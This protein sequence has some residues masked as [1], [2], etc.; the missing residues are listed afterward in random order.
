MLEYFE[1][2]GFK[3]FSWKLVWDFSA[4]RDY[5][6]N[7]DCLSS[8]RLGKVLVCGKNSVGKTN[9]GLALF[10][11]TTH[12]IGGLESEFYNYYLSAVPECEEAAFRYC[13]CFGEDRVTYS[14]RKN[15]LRG[16]TYERLELN[17]QQVLEWQL[18][19]QITLGYPLNTVHG[20]SSVKNLRVASWTT[21]L[22]LNTAL[23]ED[24]PLKQ[25]LQFVRNMLWFH[26]SDKDLHIGYSSQTAD[27]YN[28]ATDSGVLEELNLFLQEAGV[29]EQ[30]RVRMD[31]DGVSR[32]YF[33]TT[34]PI[35]FF[36]TASRGTRALYTLFYWYKTAKD[37]SLLFVDEFDAFYHHALSESVFRALKKLTKTQV[38][39]TSHNTGLLSNRILRPDC[40]FIL[41]AGKFGP[42]TDFTDREIREGNNLEKLYKSGEFD[43]VRE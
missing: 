36:G 38:I 12:L 15:A 1:V 33:D 20:F 5:A 21:A 7:H 18:N 27:Y 34:P 6:F 10:D 39:V 25:F 23:P 4:V 31:V 43:P 2:Q 41:G 13:F 30:V 42:M 8:G 14:Y 40:C 11:I 3:N 26:S 32:L 28:I 29:E 16:L 9:L 24:H 22:I 17:D 19:G 37:V 35:P